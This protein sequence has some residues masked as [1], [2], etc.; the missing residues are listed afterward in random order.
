MT[1]TEHEV[2]VFEEEDGWKF[3][4]IWIDEED[5]ETFAEEY[6]EGEWQQAFEEHPFIV[7][8]NLP[9]VIGY[10]GDNGPRLF[11]PAQYVDKITNNFDFDSIKWLDETLTI[12]WD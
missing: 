9:V 10:D 8:R 11:G 3:I 5:V 2:A 12:D 4:L 1:T 6:S 7:E